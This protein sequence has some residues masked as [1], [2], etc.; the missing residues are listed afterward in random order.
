MLSIP[1]AIILN[2]L[3][4]FGDWII[5]GDIIQWQVRRKLRSCQF[6]TLL[7]LILKDFLCEWNTHYL[8]LPL[9]FPVHSLPVW[10]CWLPVCQL[11]RTFSSLLTFAV[12]L[13]ARAISVRQQHRTNCFVCP[14]IRHLFL[15]VQK[16]AADFLLFHWNEVMAKSLKIFE[17]QTLAQFDNESPHR[18]YNRMVKL[19]VFEVFFRWYSQQ[20]IIETFSRAGLASRIPTVKLKFPGKHFWNPNPELLLHFSYSFWL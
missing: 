3:R 13:S 20:N 6:W 7:G 19:I 9:E 4:S 5:V 18:R 16:L 17:R 11:S 14:C 8:I 15:E 12:W 10:T 1:F 2:P